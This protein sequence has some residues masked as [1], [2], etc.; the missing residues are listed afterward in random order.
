MLISLKLKFFCPKLCAPNSGFEGRSRL[1]PHGPG[2]GGG[3][4]AA[5]GEDISMVKMKPFWAGLSVTS[6]CGI[7]SA[8]W[9]T[10]Q[11]ASDRACGG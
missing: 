11:T 7:V 10:R 2:I 8:Q 3:H 6:V 9:R 4:M 5:S 1:N